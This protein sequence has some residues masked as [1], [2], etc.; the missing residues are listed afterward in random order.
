MRFVVGVSIKDNKDEY[1]QVYIPVLYHT[2]H[3]NNNSSNSNKPHIQTYTQ[4]QTK[5]FSK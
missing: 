4:S 3:I 2:S 5:I 1:T